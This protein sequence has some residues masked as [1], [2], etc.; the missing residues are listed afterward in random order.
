MNA[1]VHFLTMAANPEVSDGDGIKSVFLHEAELACVSSQGAECPPAEA[2]EAERQAFRWIFDPMTDTCF[3]PVAQRNPPRL[4][5]AH[6]PSQRCSCWALSMH[7]SFEHSSR[8]FQAVEK[9]FKRARK[10]LGSAIAHGTLRCSDGLSTP[11]DKNGHFDFHPYS[12]FAPL[13][14]FKVF[15]ELP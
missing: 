9:T 3:L 2:F 6:D 8:A 11:S 12:T 5:R 15:G 7:E 14:T 4:Q 10:T 13:S 1:C